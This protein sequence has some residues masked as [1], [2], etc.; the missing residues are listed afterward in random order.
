MVN[1]EKFVLI[2]G[3]TSGIGREAALTFNEENITVIASGRNVENGVALEKEISKKGGKCHFIDCD[4]S[5]YSSIKKLFIKI[6]KF[7]DKLDYCINNASIEGAPQKISELDENNWDTVIDTNL[8]SVAMCMKYELR[9]MQENGGVIVNVSSCLSNF[10]APFT[11]SYT[12]S[13][14]GVEALTRVAAIEF[15][16]FNVRVNSIAPGAVDTPMLRRIYPAEEI[17]NMINLNP[18]SRIA[19][20]RDIADTIVWLCSDKSRHV[21]GISMLVDGGHTLTL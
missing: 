11:G 5:N 16:E 12:A 8:K 15:S 7:T 13:K 20:P 18:L 4:L 17:N 19:S 14:A 10:A 1:K 2:T 9:L 3:A 6:R 21:N